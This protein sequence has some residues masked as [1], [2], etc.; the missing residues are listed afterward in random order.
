MGN[1]SEDAVNPSVCADP[2]RSRF[3]GRERSVPGR[4]PLHG[5]RSPSEASAAVLSPGTLRVDVWGGHGTVV[6]P[7]GVGWRSGLADV[8]GVSYNR[9]IFKDPHLDIIHHHIIT[10]TTEEDFI[11]TSGTPNYARAGTV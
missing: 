10:I 4:V 5:P 7:R 2:P 6:V 11:K 1:A 8:L 9:H 3:P